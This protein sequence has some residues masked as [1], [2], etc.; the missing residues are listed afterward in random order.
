MNAAQPSPTI[1]QQQLQ[2]YDDNMVFTFSRKQ[3]DDT[4]GRNLKRQQNLPSL[5]EVT[6]SMISD[7]MAITLT[8]E[9]IEQLGTLYETP[10]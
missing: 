8:L 10:Y 1:L 6:L 5:R 4:I 9:M 2:I 3:D 7:S